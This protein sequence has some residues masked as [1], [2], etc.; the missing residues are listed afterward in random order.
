MGPCTLEA[1][2]AT[3]G[4][5]RVTL[6]R[7]RA[8]AQNQ[9][10]DP[11]GYFQG[12]VTEKKFGLEERHVPRSGVRHDHGTEKQASHLV[13]ERFEGRRVGEHRIVETMHRRRHRDARRRLH[14]TFEASHH[15][16]AFDALDA[17]FDHAVET[18]NESAHF[19]VDEHERRG[20]YGH[21]PGLAVGR[22]TRT[23][24]R[25]LHLREVVAEFPARGDANA[26]APAR[27]AGPAHGKR[28]RNPRIFTRERLDLAAR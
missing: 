25:A 2:L 23:D 9:C 5:K 15:D 28:Q 16:A 27:G 20:V 17:E 13:R 19:E 8:A 6:K 22:N 1:E 7:K 11:P 4:F 12:F 3:Q 10:V 14:E 26:Y 18:E 21:V 24:G